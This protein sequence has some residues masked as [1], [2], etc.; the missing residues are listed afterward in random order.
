M[1]FFHLIE[2]QHKLHGVGVVEITNSFEFPRLEKPTFDLVLEEE[3]SLV[4]ILQGSFLFEVL[5]KQ[6]IFIYLPRKALKKVVFPAMKLRLSKERVLTFLSLSS[7]FKDRVLMG[8]NLSFKGEALGSIYKNILFFP[9]LLNFYFLFSRTR[10]NTQKFRLVFP[11][12]GGNLNFQSR[13]FVLFF[14]S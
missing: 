4:S 14:S 9:R 2:T 10:F 1:F 8:S 12:R 11:I 6:K 13:L 3:P 5:F 7:F